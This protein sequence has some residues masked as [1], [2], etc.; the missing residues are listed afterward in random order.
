MNLLS[1]LLSYIYTCVYG[2]L[3][4]QS[5]FMLTLRHAC[6][7]QAVET[8]HGNCLKIYRQYFFPH[9]FFFSEIVLKTL[10]ARIHNTKL[11]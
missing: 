10:K 1:I 9:S 8:L 5:N 3:P 2:K 11:K 6:L 7:W 4:L